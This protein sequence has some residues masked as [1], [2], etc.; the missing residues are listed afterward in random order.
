M[1]NNIL[2][3]DVERR[4]VPLMLYMKDKD[5]A[6]MLRIMEHIKADN[7]AQAMRYCIRLVDDWLSREAADAADDSK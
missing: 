2:E 6:A 7:K 5:A 4:G 1:D 3:P